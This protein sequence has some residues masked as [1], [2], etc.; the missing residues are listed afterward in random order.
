MK[1][2]EHNESNCSESKSKTQPK[3]DIQLYNI[4][5]TKHLDNIRLDLTFRYIIYEYLIKDILHFGYLIT[6]I[7]YVTR[8]KLSCFQRASDLEVC[9][10]N[11][12]EQSYLQDAMDII[13]L[14][15]MRVYNKHRPV[16]HNTYQCYLK[17]NQGRDEREV[18]RERDAMGGIQKRDARGSCMRGMRE[19]G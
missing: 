17:V 9:L 1:H 5:R 18:N 19:E 13:T 12:A 14:D 8:K 6:Y 4:T 3:P 15:F 10:V 16:V 2:C 11:D 7:M